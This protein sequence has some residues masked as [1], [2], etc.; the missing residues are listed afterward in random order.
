MKKDLQ[1]ILTLDD[2]IWIR[3]TASIEEEIP[4]V[5]VGALIK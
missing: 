2:S 4:V 5:L 1:E 3:M